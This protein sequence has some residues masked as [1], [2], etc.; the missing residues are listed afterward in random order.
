[1]INSRLNSLSIFLPIYNESLIIKKVI[2]NIKL[3]APNVAKNW[4]VIAVNDGSVDETLKT[5]KTIS[6]IKIID[7]GINKGYGASLRSG[8]YNSKYEWIV[9]TD[10]DGQFDF[11]EIE[12]FIEKQ[13]QTNADLV[14]GYYKKR[15]VSKFKIITSKIWEITV[16]L[17]FGLWVKDIDCGFKLIR[18]KVIEKI[19]KLE[20]QRGAFISSELLIKAKKFG[21]KI[22]EIPVTHYPRTTGKG[23]GRHIRVIIQSFIDL[24]RLW[25]KLNFF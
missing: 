7:H 22:V 20:S 23:T 25:I 21:F 15:Q 9:F 3:I 18:K 11:S 1:M 6:G 2:E 13:K 12:K 5:L 17:L 14:I 24:F 16:F 19:P 10:S 4:E 8:F